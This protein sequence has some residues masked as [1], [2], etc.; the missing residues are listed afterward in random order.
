MSFNASDQ[1]STQQRYH[2][3]FPSARVMLKVDGGNYNNDL[4]RHDEDY[5]DDI[6]PDEHLEEE[7]Y[8]E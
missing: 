3:Q 1:L 4:H 6:V 2:Q 7:D 5:I 8:E